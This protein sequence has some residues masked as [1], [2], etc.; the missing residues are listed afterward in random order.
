MDSPAQPQQIHSTTIA[1]SRMRY[2]HRAQRTSDLEREGC[3]RG[4]YD[5]LRRQKEIRSQQEM[6]APDTRITAPASIP[7]RPSSPSPVLFIFARQDR[8]LDRRMLSGILVEQTRQRIT[9][10]TPKD[11]GILHRHDAAACPKDRPRCINTC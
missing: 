9:A 2:R 11:T 5:S 6:I 7:E 4:I 1:R 10:M 3:Q 8:I